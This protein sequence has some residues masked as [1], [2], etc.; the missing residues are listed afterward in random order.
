MLPHPSLL[1]QNIQIH[2]YQTEKCSSWANDI[3]KK[4][5]FIDQINRD[6]ALKL[7]L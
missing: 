4:K 3:S 6:Y 1:L 7:Y 5:A 2:R